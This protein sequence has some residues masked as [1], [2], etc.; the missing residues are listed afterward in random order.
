MLLTM[1]EMAEDTLF[2]NSL[3]SNIFFDTKYIRQLWKKHLSG[4]ND[5]TEPLWML[6]SFNLWAEKFL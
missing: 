3:D 2:K 1:R 5:F 4:M 6:M